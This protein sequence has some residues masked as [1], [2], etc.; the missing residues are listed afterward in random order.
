MMLGM[1]DPEDAV[2]YN[3]LGVKDIDTP[4]HRALALDAAHQSIVL[5]KN[6]KGLLPLKPGQTVALI[7]THDPSGP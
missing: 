2:S 4:E 3:K 1:F 5:L 7:G 6:S